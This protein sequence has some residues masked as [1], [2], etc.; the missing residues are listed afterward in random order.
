[1]KTYFVDSFTN[2]KF[3]GNPAAVCLPNTELDSETM[4]NIATEIGFSETAFIKQISDNNYSIRFFSPKTEIPL[5][6]HATLASSKIVFDTTSFE[7]IKF[8]NAENV[9]L[10]IAKVGNKIKMQFPVYNTQE[11]EVP[12]EMTDALGI[13]EISNKRYSPKNKIILIEIKCAIELANLKP[14]FTA[15]VNSYSGINGVL[16]TAVSDTANFD[17]HY[18]YFWPWSGTNEDPVTGGVQTFLTKYWSERLNKTKFNAYQSS[19]RTGTMSTELVADKVFILGE[20]VTVL[21]GEF[22]L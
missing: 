10:P 19:S 12:Q 9:E 8:I 16:V 5:C 14:D 18:R 2:E 6:G 7:N 22:N 3:K 15:L 21:E 13:S 20:A 17:F 11:T 4:Q 1:M